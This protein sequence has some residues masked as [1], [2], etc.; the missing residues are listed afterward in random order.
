MMVMPVAPVMAVKK[1]HEARAF[2]LRFLPL[3]CSN[4]V[5]NE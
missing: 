5:L 2:A 1:A 3:A 4:M